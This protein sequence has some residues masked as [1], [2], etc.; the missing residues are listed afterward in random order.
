MA[1][2]GPWVAAEGLGSK[3]SNWLGPPAI[4]SKMQAFCCLRNMVYQAFKADPSLPADEVEGNIPQTLL[5]MNSA[6]VNAYTKA[7]GKT[8]LAQAL[9]K[10]M[11]DDDILTALYERTLARKPRPQELATCKRYLKKVGNRQEALEDVF[12]SL[13]NSTEFLTKQ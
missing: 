7:S 9:A 5:M 13:V 2:V 1:F 6:L 8:F 3:V 10:G 12:W 4:Q 11:R